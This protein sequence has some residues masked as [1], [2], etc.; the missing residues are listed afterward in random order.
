MN[1]PDSVQHL[2]RS[3]AA[4]VV[5]TYESITTLQRRSVQEFKDLERLIGDMGA[6]SAKAQGLPHIITSVAKMA[7]SDHVLILAHSADGKMCHGLLKCGTKNL[8]IRDE[9]GTMHEITPMCVL[10]FYVHESCQRTGIGLQLFNFMITHLN[11]QRAAAAAPSQQDDVHITSSK[12][13]RKSGSKPA[14][15]RPLDPSRL[16]YDRPSPKL[17]AFLAKHFGLK[18]FVPQSNNFV[19]YKVYF[20]GNWVAPVKKECE[21]TVPRTT[22]RELRE[23]KTVPKVDSIND[24]SSTAASK[25][26]QD[27]KSTAASVSTA[28]ELERPKENIKPSSVVA[29]VAHN[30]SVAPPA[31]SA[32][33]SGTVHV[34]AAASSSSSYSAPSASSL[35]MGRSRNAAPL[36]NLQRDPITGRP[37]GVVSRDQFQFWKTNAHPTV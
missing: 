18:D 36:M 14:D 1:I 19:V 8:F 22:Q 15:T 24:R 5:L 25:S 9:R 23:A 10:D 3:S 28:A 4:P 7:H 16:A 17:L 34:A 21:V 13:I 35:P 20:T 30:A 32:S 11:N 29:P 12:L 2:F 26:S 27:K 33:A 37:I 31:S 6:N